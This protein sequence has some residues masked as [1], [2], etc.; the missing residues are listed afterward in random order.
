LLLIFL[1]LHK[2]TIRGFRRPLEQ[3][4]VSFLFIKRHVGVIAVKHLDRELCLLTICR[5][6]LLK[7]LPFDF[8]VLAVRVVDGLTVVPV[9]V[10]HA[11]SIDRVLLLL[12]TFF[13]A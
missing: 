13:A 3:F 4:L 6:H 5:D 8:F 7:T 2:C 11:I 10:E 1:T 9:F 12:D